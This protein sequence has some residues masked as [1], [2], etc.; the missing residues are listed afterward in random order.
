MVLGLMTSPTRGTVS[1]P[2][3]AAIGIVLVTVAITV[4]GA[5][6]PA[7]RAASLEPSEALRYE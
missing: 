7:L 6:P 5:V 1:R 2:A 4:V 3:E